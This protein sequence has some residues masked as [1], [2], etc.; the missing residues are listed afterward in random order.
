MLHG[1]IFLKTHDLHTCSATMTTFHRGQLPCTKIGGRFGWQLHSIFLH[2]EHRSFITETKLLSAM[3]LIWK[4]K[5]FACAIHSN[6][7]LLRKKR[8]PMTLYLRYTVICL[9]CAVSILH[10]AGERQHISR[11]IKTVSTDMCSLITVR[12][13]K[14]CAAFSMWKHM[15][16]ECIEKQLQARKK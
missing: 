1:V 5:I 6:G 13:K 4:Q 11:V 14:S 9:R 16:S 15:S 10:C 3:H 7:I 12:R 2:R 8:K